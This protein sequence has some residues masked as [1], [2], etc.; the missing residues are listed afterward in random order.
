M[1][2]RRTCLQHKLFGAKDI[3]CPGVWRHVFKYNVFLRIFLVAK[4]ALVQKSPE[5]KGI[6][7]EG[8]WC[9][10]AQKKELLIAGVNI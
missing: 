1:L 10:I 6:S 8:S 5:V 4:K 2:G 3:I 9:K 7:C